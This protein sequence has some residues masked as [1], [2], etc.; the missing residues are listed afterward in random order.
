[1]PVRTRPEVL[2]LREVFRG[3]DGRSLN[4]DLAASLVR[5][6]GGAAATSLPVPVKRSRRA[7]DAFPS[8]GLDPLEANKGMSDE[9]PADAARTAEAP[10][11]A[12]REEDVQ[13]GL[14]LAK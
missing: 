8:R 13:S 2:E 11:E 1:M 12:V 9:V 3:G 5:V 6:Q 4:D 7:M 14:V 10:A